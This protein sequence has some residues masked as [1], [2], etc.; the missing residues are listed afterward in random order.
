MVAGAQVSAWIWEPRDPR[1]IVGR[2]AT[3]CAAS[4]HRVRLCLRLDL[5]HQSLLG[6]LH[7]LRCMCAANAS[8]Q[9]AS[10][11]A[12]A[13]LTLSTPIYLP[14]DLCMRDQQLVEC[15]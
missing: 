7:V 10:S 2:S 6:F 12:V 15:D 11:D 5:M 3:S 4:A 9:D 8:R 1:G 13:Q 14:N